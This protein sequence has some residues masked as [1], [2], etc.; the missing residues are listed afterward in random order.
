MK[1]FK[2][3]IVVITGAGEGIGRALAL[4]F[5]D[6]GAK[7]ILNDINEAK[8]KET[9]QYLMNNDIGSIYYKADVSNRS[10]VYD[11][12]NFVKAKYGKIDLLIN[13]AGVSIG[14]MTAV[15]IPQAINEWI[16]GINYWGTVNCVNSFRPLMQRHNQAQIVNICS[17]YSYLGMYKRSAYCA[18]KAALNAYSA[19]LRQELKN[20]GINVISVFPGMVNSQI[21]KNSRG[22][23]N[24]GDKQATL[25]LYKKCRALSAKDAAHQ[26]IQG[27]A[28]KKN[29]IM[30]GKD[31]K[32]VIQLLRFLPTV[33]EDLVNNLVKRAESKSQTNT[34]KLSEKKKVFALPLFLRSFYNPGLKN[35][36]ISHN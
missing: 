24:N 29:R 17:L 10:E 8:L 1:F 7:V 16:F 15:E 12:A 23:S 32:F 14:R 13:N 20:D 34:S 36:S 19:S 31:A 18:S 2:N 11:F 3:R 6:K 22:W 26:I 30:V 27:I 9:Q 4:N 33:G 21:V 35:S 28:K 5:A 25:N